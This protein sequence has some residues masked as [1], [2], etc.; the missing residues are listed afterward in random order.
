MGWRQ[1]LNPAKLRPLNVIA[2]QI[3]TQQ[4]A[5]VPKPPHDDD[6]RRILYF[7]HCYFSCDVK[8]SKK[9]NLWKKWR[10]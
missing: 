4:E 7:A 5:K 2:E 6:T 3:T 8:T 9:W 10:R 1:A